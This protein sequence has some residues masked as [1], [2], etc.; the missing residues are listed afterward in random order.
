MLLETPDLET[1]ANLGLTLAWAAAAVVLAFVLTTVLSV[2]VRRVGRRSPLARE[3]S[4]RMRRPTRA[5]LMTAAVAVAVRLTAD[6]DEP[7]LPALH[8]VLLVAGIVCFTWLVGALAFVIEDRSLARLRTDVVDNRHARRVRTQIT[9]VRRL[10]IAVLVV[11]GVAAVLLTFPGARAAGASIFASAGLISIVAGLAAQTSLANVFAGMQIAFTDAIRVDDVVVLEGEWGRIEEITLTYVVVHVWDDRRLVLPCTYFTTTP[12]QNW[13]R[14]SAELLGTVE[15]DL[16]FRVPLR[17]MR[18]ELARLLERTELWDERVGILQVTEATGG[19]VR[20]RVLVSAKDGPT[21]FDLRC[22]VREG[23]VEWLQR[24][25]PGAL[26]RTRFEG[27]GA[28]GGGFLGEPAL[29]PLGEAEGGA[30]PE[31]DAGADSADS[32]DGADGAGGGAGGAEGLDGEHD[33]TRG[34]DDD[35]GRETAA[36]SAPHRRSVRSTRPSGPPAVMPRRPAA[37]TVLLGPAALTPEA[38]ET[39]LI[40]TVDDAGGPESS[41]L[42]SGSAAAEERSRAFGGPGEEALEER[43]AAAAAGQEPENDEDPARAPRDA[44]TPDENEEGTE[45]GGGTAPDGESAAGAEPQRRSR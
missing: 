21:L 29:P 23:L 43:N 16:D 13:T 37:E 38:E 18:A 2:A 28:D 3:L 27:L 10:T 22:F 42:F 7:W 9:V 44:D 19:F 31:Q 26:P 14:R 20:V 4:L 8:H 15:L 41:A 32:A 12:F 45:P 5:L 36:G 30:T 35:G 40:D 25:A 34:E 6:P 1:T 33:D 39:V 24:S 11:C 17:A